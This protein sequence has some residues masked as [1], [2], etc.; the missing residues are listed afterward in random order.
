MAR[1]ALVRCTDIIVESNIDPF[2]LA[3]RL[4]SKDV[5]SEDIYKRMRYMKTLYSNKEHLQ[6]IT[7]DIND[8][9]THNASILISFL[10]TLNEMTHQDLAVS[11]VKKYKGMLYRML[12]Y[13]Y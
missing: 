1:R 9:V 7:D 11:I 8:H 5:I 3:R 12:F 10:S 6:I 2:A 13:M 4:Y